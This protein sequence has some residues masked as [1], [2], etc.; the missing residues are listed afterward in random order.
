MLNE[1]TRSVVKCLAQ[2]LLIAE[3]VSK[4][5]VESL[6]AYGGGC[7]FVCDIVDYVVT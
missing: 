3:N 4:G 1:V 6:E 7:S 2:N 5:V